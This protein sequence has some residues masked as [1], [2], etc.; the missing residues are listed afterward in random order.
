MKAAG[1]CTFRVS[2]WVA[3]LP[4]PLLAFTVKVRVPAVPAAGVPVIA[5]V[6]A[7]RL[8]PS[9]RLPVVMLKAGAGKPAAARVKLPAVDSWKFAVV[10][11][12]NEGARFT[13]WVS[14]RLVL[15]P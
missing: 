12:V 15:A 9:G 11:L 14:T 10:A 1:A 3:S 5:P 4:T 13:N 7:F 2:V 6:F 8:R